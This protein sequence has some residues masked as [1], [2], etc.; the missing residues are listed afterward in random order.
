MRNYFLILYYCFQN[1]LTR[2][3]VG[4]PA[5]ICDENEVICANLQAICPILDTIDTYAL[6]SGDKPRLDNIRFGVTQFNRDWR[7]FIR[8]DGYV[9]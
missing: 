1:K 2:F 7:A 6:T 4:I 3:S 9:R 5:K 8:I